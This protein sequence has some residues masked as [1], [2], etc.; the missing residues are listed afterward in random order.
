M[1]SGNSDEI[2][3]LQCVIDGCPITFF[4]WSDCNNEW[5]KCICSL[6]AD[7]GQVLTEHAAISKQVVSLY[8]NLFKCG[9]RSRQCLF[10]VLLRSPSG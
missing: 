6:K 10:G 9:H 7:T 3:F 1:S 2:T 4:L 5:K 8:R